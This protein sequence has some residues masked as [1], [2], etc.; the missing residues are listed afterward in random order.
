MQIEG[1]VFTDEVFF[2]F[3]DYYYVCLQKKLKKEKYT[4]N[5]DGLDMVQHW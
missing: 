1:H 3:C 5:H 4:K 2:E